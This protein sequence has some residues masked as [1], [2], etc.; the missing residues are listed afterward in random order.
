MIGSKQICTTLIVIIVIMCMGWFCMGNRGGN[1]EPPPGQDPPTPY[2]PTYGSPIGPDY[3][4]PGRQL[5]GGGSVEGY[6]ST[7]PGNIASHLNFNSGVLDDSLW[8]DSKE[9]KHYYDTVSDTNLSNLMPGS[10]SGKP[11][12]DCAKDDSSEFAR[13]SVSPKAMKKSE[14]LR[15][16]MRLYEETR[17]PSGRITGQVSLLRN[18]VT[19]LKNPIPIGDTQFT[20]NDSQGRQDLIA[21][22]MGDYPSDTSC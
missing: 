19:P 13:F 16:F 6:G 1:D 5:V 2:T 12:D 15:G 18:A 17:S 21:A 3:E 9:T 8:S 11:T 7:S 22:A 14:E 10:W 20:F 4:P